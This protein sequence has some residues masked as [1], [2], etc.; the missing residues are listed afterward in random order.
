MPNEIIVDLGNSLK[1]VNEMGLRLKNTKE[2]TATISETML[3][4]ISQHFEDEKGPDG[5][6]PDLAESTKEERRKKGYW[7]GKILQR[8]SRGSGLL[9]SLQPEYDDN[10]AGVTTNKVYAAAHNFGLGE[11][12][13]VASGKSM[14]AIPQREFMWLSTEAREEIGDTVSDYIVGE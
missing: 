8:Q 14:P 6:W 1:R 7:P 3:S 11:R 2:L 5:P 10:S 12:S 9:G 4:D 13:V